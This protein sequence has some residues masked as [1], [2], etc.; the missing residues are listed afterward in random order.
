MASAEQAPDRL[1]THP[2]DKPPAESPGQPAAGPRAVAVAPSVLR[3]MNQ[4]LLLDQLFLSGPATRPQLAK[5][6]GLSLPTVIA[7]LADLEHADLVR[8]VGRT[9]TAHGRPATRYGVNPSAG[10]AVGVDV[11]RDLLRLAVADLAGT[12]LAQLE[13]RNAARTSAALVD[14]IADAVASVAAAA[15]IDPAAITHAVVGSPGVYDRSRGRVLYAANLPGWQRVGLAESLRR[16]LGTSL[17]VDNDANLAALG[18]HHHGAGRGSQHFVYAHVD[19]GVGVGLILGGRLYG[20]FSGAAGEVGYLPAHP[21]EWVPGHPPE[22]V[23]G[24]SPE[25]AACD[26][27]ARDQATCAHTGGAG[28][29]RGARRTGTL[30]DDLASA[31]VLR[32][33]KEAGLTGCRTVEAV[34]AAARAGS[35][36]AGEV[37]RRVA[38]HLARLLA[39][40]AAF[41]DPELIVLGGSIGRQLDVLEPPTR[42]VLAQLGPMSPRLAVGALGA[43]AVLHGALATG[44][45]RAREIVFTGKTARPA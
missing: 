4:R 37:V 27:P 8:P 11:G 29:R 1:T 9:S 13:V 18:E 5:D 42:A 33:A 3:E 28:G 26:H 19:V 35:R 23:P 16:R 30:E 22:W 7:A 31:A 15:S 39:S 21:P 10:H 12:R 40:T 36:P 6:A 14:G 41:L 24:H 20:G 45:A 38:G 43:E 2:L 34:F 17:T 44:V 25:P 32:Y